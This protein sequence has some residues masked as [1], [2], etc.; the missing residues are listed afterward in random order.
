[1]TIMEWNQPI[2][3]FNDFPYFSGFINIHEYVNYANMITCIFAHG[4]KDLSYL[5]FRTNFSYLW[6]KVAEILFILYIYPH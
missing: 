4:M 1:M 3:T 6:L 5:S 2:Y